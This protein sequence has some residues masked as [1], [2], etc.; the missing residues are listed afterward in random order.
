MDNKD[1]RKLEDI[2]KENL[3]L[4]MGHLGVTWEALALSAGE[5][6]RNV[7]NWVNYGQPTIRKLERLAR[8]VGCPAHSLLDPDFNPRDYEK[9]E[10]AK[11]END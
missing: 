2:L 5:N 10:I 4:R 6:P 11:N 9:P 8:V 1:K 7:R 3:R